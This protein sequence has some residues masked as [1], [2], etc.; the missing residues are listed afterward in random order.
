MK[1][2][3]YLFKSGELKQENHTLKYILKYDSESIPIEQIE[4]IHVFGEMK[5]NK[6]VLQLCSKY[7]IGITFYTRYGNIIGRFTST[8]YRKGKQ[9]LEQSNA[10]LTLN[11][12]NEIISKIELA[13]ARNCLSLVKYYQKEGFPLEDVVVDIQK[14]MEHI[15]TLNTK[16]ETYKEHILLAEARLKQVYYRMFDCILLNTEFKFQSRMAHP[17]GNEF[18]ALM[19]FG[20]ALLYGDLLNAIEKS[21][22]VPEISFIHGHTRHNSGSLQYDLADIFKPHIIDRLCLRLVRGSIINLSH[23][24]KTNNNGMFLNEEG[25]KLFIREYDKMLH[26]TVMDTRNNRKYSYKQFLFREI[27]ELSD[28]IVK[29]KK[30]VPTYFKW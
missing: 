21:N 14:E 18:N 11:I 27:Y 25:R 15:K 20:Y 19:S 4:H 16:E 2:N 1:K 10:Y 29:G 26:K 3:L 24:Y 5:M 6:R 28:F 30:Y 12:R 23:F 22:L 17:P 13:I 8:S 9:I 7:K